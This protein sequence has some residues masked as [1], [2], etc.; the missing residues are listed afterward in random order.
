MSTYKPVTI[1][2]VARAAGVSAGTVSR[3]LNRRSGV[4]ISEATQKHV[5]EVADRLGYQLNPVASA[6]RTQQTGLIGAI[7][8]DINDPFLSLMAREAQRIAHAMGIEL[9]MGHAEY[10]L[11]TVQR[12]LRFMQHWFDGLLIIG[13][14][15]GDQEIFDDLNKRGT[16]YVA[17]ACGPNSPT[18]RVNIDEAQGIGLALDYLTDL[19]HRRIGFIGDVGHAGTQARLSAFQ[20]IIHAKTLD[21]HEDYL[22][23]TPYTRAGAITSIQR[24]LTLPHPPTAVLCTSDLQALGAVAGAWQAGW[25]VP[26][27]VSVIGIDDIE[28]GRYSYPPLTTIRQPVGDMATAA[29]DLL[30]CLVRETEPVDTGQSIIVAPELIVRRSCARVSFGG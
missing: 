16:P 1:A 29:I 27:A 21:W 3:V 23:P 30:L 10:D 26:E 19:G 20:G 4:K 17:V 7:I 5:L 13:D 14:M 8:R 24:L 18:P 22:Q 12:Q 6:L 15:P 11:L 2:D 9:L 25:R 28:E